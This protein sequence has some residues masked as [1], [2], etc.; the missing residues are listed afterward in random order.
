M[1]KELKDQQ[2]LKEYVAR[3]EELQISRCSL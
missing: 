3:A 2:V 1:V